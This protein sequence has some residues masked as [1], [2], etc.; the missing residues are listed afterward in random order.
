M[1]D[2]TVTR[3]SAIASQRWG[4]LTTA[5]AA[6]AGIS[7]NQLTRMNANGV[8][9]RVIQGVYRFAGAPELEHEL[10]FATWL[11]LGGA[12]SASD[13]PPGVVAGG[14]TA[15]ELHKI[16][17]LYPDAREFLVPVRKTTRL[18]GVRLRV[19]ALEPD[20]VTIVD[21]LPILTIERTIADLVEQW[22]DL[23]LVADVVRDAVQ[24]AR[25]L[26]PQ[27]LADHL[28]VIA[29]RHGYPSGTAFVVELF[30]LAGAEPTGTYR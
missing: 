12:G 22:T 24:S 19:R 6:D 3:L 1:A 13:S 17:D 5:Q 29:G 26:T 18:P 25:L 23:S 16:G 15:A 21:Q 4:L 27:R 11:A 9:E 7:R 28:D 2:S 20:D 14:A 30:E 8:L 10:T